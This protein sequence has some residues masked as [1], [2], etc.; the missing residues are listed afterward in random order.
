MR[1]FITIYKA[2]RNSLDAEIQFISSYIIAELLKYEA[3]TWGII[4]ENGFGL[5]IGRN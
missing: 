1:K 2:L 4:K 5:C 3:Y